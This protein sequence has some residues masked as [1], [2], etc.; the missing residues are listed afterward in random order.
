[1]ETKENLIARLGELKKELSFQKTQ[2]NSLKLSINGSFGKLGSKYSA[3]YSPDLLIYVTVTGQLAL[4]MLIERLHL[5]GVR[6]ISANTDGVVL[7]YPESLVPTVES[8]CFDWSLSTSYTLEATRYKAIASRDVNNYVAVTLSGNIKGKGCFAS[9]GLSKNPDG[10]IIYTAVAKQVADGTPY[11][12]TIR[13]C[14]DIREFVTVRRV[15]GGAVWRGEKLGK[16]VRFYISTSV[17]ENECILYATNN[18]RVP[19]SAGAK[20]C[21]VLPEQFPGDVDYRYYE[22]EAEKLLCEIG[23]TE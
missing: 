8:V 11:Q 14:R 7:H 22:T 19:K 21:M 3:L 13:A 12:E 5:A 23:W 15:Q 2:M 1:M 6:C 16:A 4:L 10:Q 9:S 20:P 18:N 17:P